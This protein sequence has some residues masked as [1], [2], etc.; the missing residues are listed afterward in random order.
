[1]TVPGCVAFCG[2]QGWGFAGL[3]Y[4]QECW[5]GD[6]VVNG[7][8]KTGGDGSCQ[9]PCTGDVGTLCGGWAMIDIY[10]AGGAAS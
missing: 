4:S 8:A 1:M 3:E 6:A 2:G 10:Q 9:M 7:A 5:C